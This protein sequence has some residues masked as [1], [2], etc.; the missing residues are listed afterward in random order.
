VQVQGWDKDVYSVSL[1]KAAAP[2]SDTEKLLPQI[3]LS[4]AGGELS[5]AGPSHDEDVATYL[6]IRAP[7]AAALDMHVQNGPM[8][9]YDADG[10]I[11][12]RA[13]NGPVSAKGC[14]GDLDLSAENGPVSSEDNGGNLRLRSQNGPIDVSLSGDRWNGSGLEAH[15]VNGP[16]TLTLPQGYQSG[17][18]VESDGHGPF[19]CHASACSEGRKTWSDNGKRVEFGSG[20]TKVH[21]SVVNG[22][23]TVD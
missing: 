10:K 16:V 23:V 6:L 15:T 3:K 20:P 7:K 22:P 13:V 9:L 8:S 17:V 14:T 5:V 19:S 12:G 4:L 2:G 18:V 21:V 11:T 1:C